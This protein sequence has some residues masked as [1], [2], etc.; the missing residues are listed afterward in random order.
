MKN[1]ERLQRRMGFYCTEQKCQHVIFPFCQ[2]TRRWISYCE[3]YNEKTCLKL[4]WLQKNQ[5][6]INGKVVTLVQDTLSISAITSNGT[7]RLLLKPSV[8]PHAE[9]VKAWLLGRGVQK[10]GV[11]GVE[12][13]IDIFKYL[14]T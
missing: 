10:I 13:E 8:T 9:Q 14:D 6:R 3:S 11:K 5:R 7:A 2:C 4:D 1:L 12:M